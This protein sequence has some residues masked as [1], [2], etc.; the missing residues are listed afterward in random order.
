MLAGPVVLVIDT[1]AEAAA[2]V[3]VVVCELELAY[4]AAEE[5]AEVVVVLRGSPQPHCSEQSLEGFPGAC[6]SIEWLFRVM[7]V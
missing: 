6:C 3:A 1:A 2:V 7:I 5:A 4:E